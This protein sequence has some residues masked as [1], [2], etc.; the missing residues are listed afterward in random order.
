M[1]Y[2]L[3]RVASWLKTKGYILK[4]IDC[5][6]AN[7]TRTVSKRMWKV[8]K[9]CSTEEYV[10]SKWSGFRPADDERIEYCFGLTP[11]DLEKRLKQI[12]AKA[13]SAQR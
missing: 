12:Q 8:R 10:P 2:G 4:L 3:L 6:E 7:R 9:I 13:R 11:A 5:L 1:P